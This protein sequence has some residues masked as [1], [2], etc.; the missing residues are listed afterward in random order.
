MNYKIYI[1]FVFISVNLF[2]SCK[3]DNEFY[4]VGF[5]PTILLK[6]VADSLVILDKNNPSMLVEFEYFSKR[7]YIDYNLLLA[8]DPTLTTERKVISAGVGEKYFLTHFVLDSLMNTMH[9]KPG[10]QAA[11]YWKVEAK[12]SEFSTTDEIRRLKVQRFK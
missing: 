6:P 12:N 1:S 2:F 5:Q 10:E 4:E 11:I 9:F 7:P 8:V 3:S